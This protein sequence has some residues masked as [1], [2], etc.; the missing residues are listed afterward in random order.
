MNLLLNI[1]VP[2]LTQA[3]T[4]YSQA[5][6]LR[7]NRYLGDSVV[8]MLG[9]AVPVYLL[10]K[11][12]DSRAT[13]RT[14]ETRRYDRHWTP[15]HLDVVVADLDIAIRKAVDAGATLEKPARQSKWGKLALMSDPF[16]NG[17]CLVQ[18]LGRGYDEI[19]TPPPGTAA[20]SDP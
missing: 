9:A 2:D 16:G 6:D 7:I 14:D 1:D 20:R 18:F 13:S 19:A 10:E 12:A 3:I 8:E 15:V 5:F 17:F 4:F 11:A